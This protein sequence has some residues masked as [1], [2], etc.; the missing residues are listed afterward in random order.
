MRFGLTF[1]AISFVFL[2]TIA[3]AVMAANFM[4]KTILS[5]HIQD[6]AQH[7]ASVSNAI[8]ESTSSV[9]TISADPFQLRIFDVL[10]SNHPAR[11]IISD[12]EGKIFYDSKRIRVNMILNI[13]DELRI[14]HQSA[15]NQLLIRTTD[16]LK[17]VYYPPEKLHKFLNNLEDI[18]IVYFAPIHKQSEIVGQIMLVESTLQLAH[19]VQK[20]KIKF[21]FFMAGIFLITAS[22]AFLAVQYSVVKPVGQLTSLTKKIA[23]KDLQDRVDIKSNDEL[24]SLSR[25]F[26][27]MVYNLE[28]MI[29]E[30]EDQNEGLIH[31]SS[32][33]EARNEEINKKM[34]LIEYD[35]RLA[36][37]IQQELLPQVYPRIRNLLISAANFPVGE[38]GG[39]CFD[40]YKRDDYMASAFI[41]DVSGKGIAAALVM[42]MATILFSQLKDRFESPSQ[43]FSH[44]NE[45]M[46]RHFGS[47]HS[48]Y[49]TCFFLN[50]DTR[51]MQLTYSCAGH[52]PPLLFRPETGKIETLEAEGFGLGMFNNV[53]YQEKSKSVQPGDKIILYTDGVTDCRNNKGEMFGFDRLRD[54]V[55]QNPDANT[56]RLT[57]FI[58]EALE[59]FAGQAPRQDDLTV[60]IFEIQENSNGQA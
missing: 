2:L 25:S 48:I 44:V 52:T 47:H 20:T 8:D 43:I 49:L 13:E 3:I 32:E 50:V 57:H 40:F 36:H 33:L 46:Y 5:S 30:T 29:R 58:V 34:Q 37:N 26:N 38:I 16:N 45:I 39:D 15:N 35:L 23:R 60:L 10:A 53:T 24:G 4:Q 27:T 14:N 6:R 51:N 9:S 12:L 41:G 59:D 21:Y 28:K 31:L 17:S 56:Y 54:L 11:I 55:L 7:M 19:S 18:S 1:K 22:I 42:S